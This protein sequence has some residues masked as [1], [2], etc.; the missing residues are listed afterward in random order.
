MPP[1]LPSSQVWS[2][3]Q[4]RGASHIAVLTTLMVA[5]AATARLTSKPRARTDTAASAARAMAPGDTTVLWGPRSFAGDHIRYWERFS[6]AMLP[7]KQYVMHVTNSTCAPAVSGSVSLNR[8][9]V[10][11]NADIQSGTRVWDRAVEVQPSDS[12]T[13]EVTAVVLEGCQPPYGLTVA[14][15]QINDWSF[16]V[17]GFEQLSRGS[18]GSDV[19][20]NRTFTL[21]ANLGAPYRLWIVNGNADG[22]QRLSGVAAKINGVPVL[23]TTDITPQTVLLKRTVSLVQG[24]N[25][26]QV[27]L[28]KDRHAQATTAAQVLGEQVGGRLPW[29]EGVGPV[30]NDPIELIINSTWRATLAVTGAEGLPPIGSAGN[31]LLP[32]LALKLS[33]RLPPTCDA[34]RAAQAVRATLERDPPYGAQVRFRVDSPTGGWNAPAFAPWLEQSIAR[35]SHAVYGREAV[36]IGCGGTIPFMGMLGERFPGTQFFITGVLGP[37]ANAH[38]P[39]EF[40]HLD[41]TRKLTACVSLVLADHAA[42]VS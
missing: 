41:Y 33:L 13:V 23:S 6:I 42:T 11:S 31:V 29:A 14:L 5:I 28:P 7:Q 4:S 37:H 32:R 3:L 22:T 2:R 24:Q 25:Q 30:S 1:K 17:Y 35:A 19:T 9:T 39:N 15:R 18:G 40:L 21:P 12:I 20:F 8:T 36:N 27:T 10:V 16:L 26:L 38:G 34:A